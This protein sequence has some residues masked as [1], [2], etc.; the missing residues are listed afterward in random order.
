MINIF[1]AVLIVATLAGF[2]GSAIKKLVP[3][4]DEK[5]LLVMQICFAIFIAYGA[6]LSIITLTGLKIFG[7]ADWIISGFFCGMG[8]DFINDLI[9]QLLGI[10]K[11]DNVAKG[12]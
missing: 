4:V 1:W 3:T 5:L 12:E 2:F 8:I 6:Q 7:P 10:L 9:K 11:P